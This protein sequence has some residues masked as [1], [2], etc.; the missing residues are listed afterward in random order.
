MGFKYNFKIIVDAPN[1]LDF[2]NLLTM[3]ELCQP[4][5]RTINSVTFYLIDILIRLILTFP[6][7]TTTT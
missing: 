2:R 3:L 4:L 1:H 7:S 5:A 6:V